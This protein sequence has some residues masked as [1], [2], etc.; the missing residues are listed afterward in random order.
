[1]QPI[2]RIATQADMPSLM[3]LIQLKAEFD[4]W[5]E[6][7]KAT[8]DQIRQ[9]FFSP[10]PSMHALIAELEGPAVGIATYFPTFSTLQ[11]RPG[12]WLDDL[13]VR[14]EYRSHGIGK[15][16]MKTLARLAKETNCGRIEWTVAL[17]NDRGVAFYERNGATIRYLSRCVRL[18]DAVIEQLANDPL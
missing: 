15:L 3:E 9:A 18:G 6:A 2:V 5:P 12:I 13:Y 4:G 10:A 11:A 8:S 16:I 7:F 14:E 17:S 1:M